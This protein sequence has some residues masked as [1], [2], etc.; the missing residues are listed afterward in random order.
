MLVS[1][2]NKPTLSPKSETRSPKACTRGPDIQIAEPDSRDSIPNTLNPT[3]TPTI[4]TP[5]V[6][7]CVRMGE[8]G[9][10]GGRGGGRER[11][12]G[13]VWGGRGVAS[14]HPVSYPT[15]GALNTG[16]HH[17]LDIRTGPFMYI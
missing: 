2:R 9:R 12:R 11:E 15:N 13:S 3:S 14:R 4:Q 7:V 16:N 8:W 1:I 5:G 10:G 17:V 6:P